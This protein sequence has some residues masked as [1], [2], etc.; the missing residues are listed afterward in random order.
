MLKTE[1]ERL[2]ALW[3][4]DLSTGQK[5]LAVGVVAAAFV[6]GAVIF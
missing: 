1:I 6:L 2:K 3:K 5:V 4:G